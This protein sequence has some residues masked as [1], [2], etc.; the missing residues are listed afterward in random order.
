MASKRHY[1][2]GSKTPPELDV[3][4]FLNL[5]VV[6][7]PFLL[8]TAVFSRITIME[9]DIPSGAGG[10]EN[11]PKTSIE[12]IVRENRLELG[13]GHGVIARLPNVNGEYDL[14]R[15]SSHLL[16]IKRN[17]P[18]KTDATIL[19]EPDIAYDHMVQVMDVVRVSE[20]RPD[21]DG[22][23]AKLELF[24]DVSLGEAP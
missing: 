8:I 17:N 21:A 19:I 2:R 23:V 3:T 11:K 7:V 14:G 24:P 13:N 4:A 6:L 9:L 20:Q 22:P 12:V 10:E 5:M 16:K 1:R 15:L 18:A